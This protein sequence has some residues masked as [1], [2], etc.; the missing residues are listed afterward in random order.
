MRGRGE[1]SR[2]FAETFCGD[3]RTGLHP[4]RL[5]GMNRM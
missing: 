1:F 2:G 4:V 5:M 3:D